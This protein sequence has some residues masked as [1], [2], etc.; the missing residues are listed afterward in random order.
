MQS[1]DPQEALERL[2]QPPIAARFEVPGDSRWA[3]TRHDLISLA[4]FGTRTF[5]LLEKKDRSE[6]VRHSVGAAESG[7]QRLASLADRAHRAVG[8]AKI[9]GRSRAICLRLPF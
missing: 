8:R 1:R 9:Q 3:G 5:S 6:G 2:N 4:W 7:R